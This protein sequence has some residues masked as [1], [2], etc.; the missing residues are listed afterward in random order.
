MTKSNEEQ[1]TK[2]WKEYT[3]I[4]DYLTSKGYFDQLEKNYNFFKGDQWKDAQVGEDPMPVDNII[5]SICNYK[6]GVVNQNNMSIIYSSE[7]FSED[8]LKEYEYTNQDGIIERTSF[9]KIADEVIKKLNKCADKFLE[10]NNLETDMW[11]Y[12]EENCISGIVN[13]Y[14]YKDKDDIERAEMVYGNNIFFS[15]ENEVDIQNQ[16]YVL[17]TFRRPVEQVKEEARA[18]NLNEEQISQ[19]TADNDYDEQ[20][21]NKE[22]VKN[23]NGKCLCVLKLYKKTV[24]EKKYEKRLV[25]DE[26]GNQQ[27]VEIEVGEESKTRVFMSKSTKNVIYVPDTNLGISLYPI[28]KMIWIKEKNNA[29]GRGE[30][31]DKIFNQIEINKTLARRDIAIQLAS[32]PK[33]AYSVEAIENPSALSKVGVAIEVKGKTV[34]DVKNAVD[35]LNPT[36]ISP[37]AKQF[38]DELS[39]KTKDNASASDAALGT[40]NPETASG[41][42]IIAVKDASA[43]PIN[44]HVNRYKKF[45]EDVARILFDFWQNTDTN[46]K[47][48]TWTEVDEQTG[49]TV[50][51]M[52]VIPYELMQKL[53]VSVK[54]NV[55]QTDPYSI[56]AQEQMWDN[57]FLEQKISFEEWISGLSDNSKYNKSKLEEIL[58][59]RKETEKELL[60]IEADIKEKQ[61]MFQQN[62]SNLNNQENK[63]INNMQEI[64]A[65]EQDVLNQQNE[66]RQGLE[67]L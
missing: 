15:D 66:L 12:N 6:I 13:M 40:I 23:D 67:M 20:I 21:G 30:P 46:G 59:K 3:Q 18:N 63:Q 56:Y 26:Q 54:V 44:I 50:A 14:I 42:S 24:K 49:E 10:N 52:E 27:E 55:S 61:L 64:E 62:A 22:E 31:Q 45:F 38:C 34:Q 8:D 65:I 5:S 19:I 29:R 47:T 48:V 51:K 37:D 41:R 28:A 33:L 60:N 9:R 36:Q 4:K 11:D 39:Q 58:R 1:L 2:I 53:K 32:Y 7:N 17:I 43:V 35:Y 16:E 57:L 25:T